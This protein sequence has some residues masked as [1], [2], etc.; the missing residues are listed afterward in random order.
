MWWECE[1]GRAH[2]GWRKDACREMKREGFMEEGSFEELG[3]C[4]GRAAGENVPQ[5]TEVLGKG[6]PQGSFLLSM[7]L[8]SL[9]K[10]RI[11][12]EAC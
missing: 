8:D 5:M 2:V 11:A 3:C 12:K 6:N 4:G 1:R 7:T 9:I 10:E